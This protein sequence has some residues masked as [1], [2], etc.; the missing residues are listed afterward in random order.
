[1]GLESFLWFCEQYFLF[2]FDILRPVLFI[3]FVIFF[4]GCALCR[5]LACRPSASGLALA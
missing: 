4:G 5:I 1:M 2:D 3:D